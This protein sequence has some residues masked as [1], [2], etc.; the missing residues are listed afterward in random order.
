[1]IDGCRD[2]PCALGF[3]QMQAAQQPARRAATG[4]AN[5]YEKWALQVLLLSD[6]VSWVSGPFFVRLHGP[7]HEPWWWVTRCLHL[8]PA[9]WHKY[10]YK[11]KHTHNVQVITTFL[12]RHHVA[13][14]TSSSPVPEGDSAD[15]LT[16]A[17]DAV[18]R[19][20]SVQRL[21]GAGV[22]EWGVSGRLSW[23]KSV[24]K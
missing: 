10:K 14:A 5:D 3:V 24:R 4:E 6:H 7:K 1:M 12:H 13:L 9:A 22:S 8:S 15:A 21:V 20:A 16:A 11:H 18:V 2:E 17:V 19:V 23:S